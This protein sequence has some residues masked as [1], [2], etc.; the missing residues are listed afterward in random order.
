MPLNKSLEFLVS[1]YLFYL[2]MNMSVLHACISCASCIELVP[3]EIKRESQTHWRT[4]VTDVV[5]CCGGDRNRTLE[6]SH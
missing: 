3:T 6:L 5:N 4:G 1:V 2:L